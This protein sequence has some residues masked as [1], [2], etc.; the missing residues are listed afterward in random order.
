M[1]R[2][3]SKTSLFRP[4]GLAAMLT[5][6]TMLTPALAQQEA[7][8]LAELVAAGELPPVEERIPSNPFIEVPL[9]QVGEYGG[10][11]RRAILGGGDHHNM[12]RLVGHDNLVRWDVTWSNVVPNIAADFEVND[13]ATEFTFTLRDGLRWSDGEPFTTEDIRFWYEDIFLNSELTPTRPPIF[14]QGGEPVELEVID[15]LTFKFTFPRP[16]GL[17]MQ[18]LAYGTGFYPVTYPS[19]YFQQ[20]HQDYNADGLQALIDAEPAAN[21]W[22]QLFQ[23]RGAPMHTPGFWQNPDRPV[24]HAWHLTNAYGSTERVVAERNPYYWKVDT[25]GNQL[26]YLDRITWDQVEDVEAILLKA[27]N[28][29]LDFMFRHIGR[30]SY[31]AVLVDNMERGNYRM[32]NVADLPANNA[33]LMLN[34]TIDDPVKREIYNNRDFRVGLSHAINRQ[35]IIDLIYFGVGSPGQSAPQPTS[36]LY[37]EEWSTQYTEYD[38]DLANEI[39]DNAG[40]AERNSDGTRL[41]PDGEPITII[42]MVADVFGLQYPDVMELVQGYARDVG[43]DIQ[44]RPTD[45]S[46][47][48]EMVTGG[49]QDA[50]M[51]NCNGGQ[52][53]MYSAPLCY[54]PMTD[55][56]IHYAREWAEWNAD[57]SR[58]EE[59][60]EHVQEIMAQY[61]EVTSAADPDTQ[62]ELM[63]ELLQMSTDAFFTIGLVQGAPV[64]GIVRNNM[65]N[66]PEPLPIAGELWF[67]SPNTVQFY[68]E[69]GEALP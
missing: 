14:V 9:D 24:M 65:R 34:L 35:E 52:T 2:T 68:F 30:P 42:F 41:G 55:S 27:F 47:L 6:G 64:Q 60:P 22:V 1:I 10:T 39:L 11:M 36:D 16:N 67:P 40:F 19:H 61:D 51:W 12:V 62:R 69:G 3:H 25:E 29:E 8:M 38:P 17:F 54:V 44:I 63:R 37:N 5:M 57:S 15:D 26:P 49:E 56:T 18:N 28:G 13:T 20:F 45:R 59:P 43:I 58:G 53:D 31:R 7:P 33:V 32:Y 50:Y 48:M 46:R 66:L 4:L 23:L 21:D